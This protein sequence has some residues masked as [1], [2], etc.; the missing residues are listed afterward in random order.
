[1]QPIEKYVECA[2]ELAQSVINL[3]GSFVAAGQSAS[4]TDEFMDGPFE[5]ACQLRMAQ[6]ITEN[7]RQCG[8]LTPQSLIEENA[9]RWAFAETYKCFWESKQNEST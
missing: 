5:R 4:L 2:D 6:R 7:Y 3:W 8:I 9:M 1:M